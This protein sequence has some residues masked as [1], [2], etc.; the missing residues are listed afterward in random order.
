MN[1]SKIFKVFI[2]FRTKKLV[3]STNRKTAPNDVKRLKKRN[4]AFFTKLP[5][6]R[7]NNTF[8]NVIITRNKRSFSRFWKED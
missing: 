2:P 7:V 4:V 8:K 6:Y 3:A 5:K 1:W